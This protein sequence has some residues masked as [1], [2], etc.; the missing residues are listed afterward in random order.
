MKVLHVSLS[1]LLASSLLAACAPTQSEKE[2]KAFEKLKA[3]VQAMQSE[4]PQVIDPSLTLDAVTVEGK[5]VNYKYTLTKDK[6]LDMGVLQDMTDRVEQTAKE[7]MCL[8]KSEPRLAL[9]HG[10]IVNF[11]YHYKDGR[12]ATVTTVTKDMCD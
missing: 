8:P 12:E 7:T 3:D 4:L 1:L 10:A 11:Y 6:S 5:V 9:E 2:E